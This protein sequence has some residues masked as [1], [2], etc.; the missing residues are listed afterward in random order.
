MLRDIKK[1]DLEL[2]RRWRNAP[3]VRRSMYTSDIIS[4][5][6]HSKHFEKVIN[7]P[8]ILWKIAIF[9]NVESG[10]VSFSGIGSD[11]C[12]WGFYL[13]DE[14]LGVK[15]LGRVWKA[16]EKEA[17]EFAFDKLLDDTLFCEVLSFNTSV[18]Q[19]HKKFGFKEISGKKIEI[20]GK[21]HKIIELSLSKNDYYGGNNNG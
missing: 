5:E 11:K 17:I 10:V 3:L 16:L 4:K 20:N 14:L 6:Q 15:S 7:D 8:T 1:S 19:M 18:I 13:S 2:V 12:C 21:E 9:N